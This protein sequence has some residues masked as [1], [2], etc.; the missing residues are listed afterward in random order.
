[1]NQLA[2]HLYLHVAVHFGDFA[3]LD[4]RV[5]SSGTV[6]KKAGYTS[7]PR[8]ATV[9]DGYRGGLD[10]LHKAL[11]D[12]RSSCGTC[13]S[14]DHFWLRE[15]V[16]EEVRTAEFPHEPG[17]SAATYL[18]DNI[19]DAHAFAEEA[20]NAEFARTGDHTQPASAA[21]YECETDRSQ[22][23]R[24]FDVVYVDRARLILDRPLAIL[25]E[26]W[27]QLAR[28]Y[29]SQTASEQPRWEILALDEVRVVGPLHAASHFLQISPEGRA[30][31]PT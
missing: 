3:Q 29:Y 17:R 20:V 11:I 24:K 10:V 26:E 23:T 22:D 19:Y 25:F 1:V 21:V 27:R 7:H 31:H 14:L 9:T 18:W 6:L 16:F 2:S 12:S 5:L 28:A 8:F 30:P 4:S 13:F 15:V